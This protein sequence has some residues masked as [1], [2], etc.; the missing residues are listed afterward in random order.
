[1]EL[2]TQL[3]RLEYG[4]RWLWI[5]LAT[6]ASAGCAELCAFCAPRRARADLY[7]RFARRWGRLFLLGARR[8]L[9]GS[10]HIPRD[11]AVVFASNHQSAFDIPLFHAL[12]PVTFRWVSKRAFFSWPFIGRA[13]KNMQAIGVVPGSRSEIRGAWQEAVEALKSGHNLVIFPEGTWGDREGRMLPFQKGVIRIAREANVPVVPVTIVGSN[14]VN[15]PRTREIHPGAIRMIVHKPMGP[16]TW[17]GISD[18]A[19]IEKLRNAI[20]EGLEHGAEPADSMRP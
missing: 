4:C 19:W 13:L 5:G 11:T 6:I 9:D 1:M 17:E 15:P 8:S 3:K 2:R 16:D 7:I 10:Q 18:D 20:A 14:R 12:M